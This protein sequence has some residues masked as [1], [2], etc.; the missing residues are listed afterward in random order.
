MGA[1]PNRTSLEVACWALLCWRS[2]RTLPPLS[3]TQVA[4]GQPATMSPSAHVT[5]AHGHQ[6]P[7]LALATD[8]AR[9]WP[10]D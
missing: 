6:S 4:L 2:G 7:T 9:C 1:Y 10:H 3:D 8:G 5:H